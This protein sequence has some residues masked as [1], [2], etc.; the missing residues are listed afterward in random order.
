M[1]SCLGFAFPSASIPKKKNIV[2]IKVSVKDKPVSHPYYQRGSSTCLFFNDKCPSDHI[3]LDRLAIYRFDL[4][5]ESLKD[6]QIYLTHSCEGGP[7]DTDRLSSLVSGGSLT[8]EIGEK[9]A[10]WNSPSVDEETPRFGSFAVTKGQILYIQCHEK[11]LMG[12]KIII[13]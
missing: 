6:Y 3:E 4:T 13:V 2:D 12:C 7:N 1:F 5:D 10:E 8:I 11:T 9:G